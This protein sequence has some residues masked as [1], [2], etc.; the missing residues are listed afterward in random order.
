MN[1]HAKKNNFDL[2]KFYQEEFDLF[3]SWLFN[4]LF[5]LSLEY[6]THYL[7]TDFNPLS[8][9]GISP[10]FKKN[11]YNPYRFGFGFN[12]VKKYLILIRKICEK[13]NIS[14]TNENKIYGFAYDVEKNFLKIYFIEKYQDLL[15]EDKK[16]FPKEEYKE[17]FL[18]STSNNMLTGENKENKVYL[19]PFKPRKFPGTDLELNYTVMKSSARGYVYQYDTFTNERYLQ[20]EIRLK[21]LKEIK[22]GVCD[23]VKTM[24]DYYESLNIPLETIEYV[25]PTN[26]NLYY[27]T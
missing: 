9:G 16:L 27:C 19:Y 2:S 3:N 6:C 8:F 13:R 17:Y 4:N 14:I 11:K 23:E 25:D 26:V 22:T 24:I 21:I 20:D 12:D 10:S 1:W 18:T 15:E 7:Y 5:Y